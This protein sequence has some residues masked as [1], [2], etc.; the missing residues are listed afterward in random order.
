M[1]DLERFERRLEARLMA[2]AGTARRSFDPAAVAREARTRPMSGRWPRLGDAVRW[3]WAAVPLGTVLVLLLMLALLIVAASLGGNPAPPDPARP[4][5][6]RTVVGDLSIARCGAAGVGLADGGALIVGGWDATGAPVTTAERFDPTT[7]T[8]HDVEGTTTAGDGIGLTL[9]GDGSVLITGGRT[10]KASDL[11][12]CASLIYDGAPGVET[13]DAFLY[14]PTSDRITAI[15]PM[16]APRS[17]HATVRLDDGRVLL[18]GGNGVGVDG[19]G[20]GVDGNPDAL[21]TAE[22][23]DPASETFSATGSMLTARGWAAALG[24]HN[25][26]L[27]TRLSDGTVLVSGGADFSDGSDPLVGERYDPTTGSF[28]A[29]RPVAGT[30]AEQVALPGRQCGLHGVCVDRFE[31]STASFS[32]AWEPGHASD[33]Q[34]GVLVIDGDRAYLVD[35]RRVTLGDLVRGTESEVPWATDGFRRWNA[36]ALL[37]DGSLL[38]AGGNLGDDGPT[39]EAELFVP[40]ASSADT[41]PATNAERAMSSP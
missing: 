26:P 40:G 1:T 33:H 13:A 28:R 25:E 17:G 36:L 30:T 3:R 11:A 21:A 37:H 24:G 19:N 31:T 29:P 23:F 2:H 32:R 16:T 6:D 22:L 5:L 8:F 14:D 18:V 38:V 7:R 35:G 34:A 20:I 9:L 12:D 15:A 4:S 39:T 27:A 10:S 41:G